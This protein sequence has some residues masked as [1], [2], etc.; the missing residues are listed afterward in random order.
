MSNIYHVIMAGGVG[1][2]FWPRSR[3]TQPKQLLEIM[4]PETM[5]RLTVERLKSVS[6]SEHILIVASKYLCGKIQKIIP[7]IPRYN[8]IIE[9]SGKNTAPAIGLAAVNIYHRDA[10]SVMAVYPADHVILDDEIFAEAVQNGVK[11][12]EAKPSLV[13]MG[14]TPAFPSTGYGYIQ[15]DPEKK[16]FNNCIFKIKTFAEKPPKETAK[17]F[18]DSGDFLWNSGMF[19]WQTEIILLAMKTFM[20]ELHESLDAIF[21]SVS[22]DKYNIVLDREW[23]LIKPE[24]IDYGI[25]EKA[26]NVYVLKADFRWSD[27]G[28]WK[29][30]YDISSKNKNNNVETGEIITIKTSKSLIYSPHRLTAVVGMKN[31]VVIH[32]DDAVLVADMNSTES[33]KKVVEYLEKHNLHEYL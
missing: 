31:V 10:N 8:Y 6:D 32:L 4:G 19:I 15:Y 29:A 20:P 28:S 22:S 3:K 24:S 30:L 18:L 23:E 27:L 26:K 16:P 9:P 21:D 1:S 33:V 5:I 12:A 17:R 11:M 7:E 13:T 25:L 14:I 2:R